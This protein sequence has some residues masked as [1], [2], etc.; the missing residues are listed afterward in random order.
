MVSFFLYS[1]KQKSSAVAVQTFYYSLVILIHSSD[2]FHFEADTP[3][4]VS[5]S[6]SASEL[7]PKLGSE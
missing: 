6:A 5:A 3:A 4:S 1:F 2:M 7:K